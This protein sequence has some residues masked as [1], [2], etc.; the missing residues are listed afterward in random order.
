MDIDRMAC[1]LTTARIR[2]L[3]WPQGLRAANDAILSI[4]RASAMGGAGSVSALGL[5]RWVY[6][7]YGA[8]AALRWPAWAP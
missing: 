6:S 1:W 5:R 8:T 7:G 2:S 4:H 3:A